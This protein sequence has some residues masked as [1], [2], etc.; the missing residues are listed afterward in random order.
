V[1]R[2]E[3]KK[4]KQMK[5]GSCPKGKIECKEGELSKESKGNI[6]WS[7]KVELLV[8]EG[9]D[10]IGWTARAEKCFEVQDI[11]ASENF[12]SVFITIE[13]AVGIWFGVWRQ[14]NQDPTSNALIRRFQE[15]YGSNILERLATL[16]FVCKLDFEGEVKGGFIILF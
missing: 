9:A 3:V 2:L 7:K 5:P 13:S 1:V 16:G 4:K 8:F 15:S 11:H 14:T 12:Q 10:Q 6:I